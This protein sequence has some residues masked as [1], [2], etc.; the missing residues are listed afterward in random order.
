MD[1]DGRATTV[2]INEVRTNLEEVVMI[3]TGADKQPSGLFGAAGFTAVAQPDAAANKPTYGLD[4]ISL[5]CFT[6]MKDVWEMPDFIVMHPLD[7]HEITTARD[8]DG[9]LQFMHPTEAALMRILG[10]PV[11]LS[12]FTAP[13][14]AQGNVCLGAFRMNAALVDRRDLTIARTNVHDANFT[15]DVI[16][17]KGSVRAA[18]AR[19]RD[20][21]FAKVTS[22]NGKKS[23]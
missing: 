19:F 20:K 13:N 11:I 5:A 6:I 3:G 9:N 17:I 16:T 8:D 10:I 1:V 22:F 14:A 2:L 7:W 12:P 18:V 15:K 23:Q 21:A 4:S